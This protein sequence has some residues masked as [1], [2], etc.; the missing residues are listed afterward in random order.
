MAIFFDILAMWSHSSIG[1]ER[2]ATDEK[3]EGSN[4]SGT[5]KKGKN[6]EFFEKFII[7]KCCNS[8]FYNSFFYNII[9]VG[10][11]IDKPRII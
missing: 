8:F 9:F 7:T 11:I 5:S 6:N 3:V 2:L 1:L 4:P 10:N